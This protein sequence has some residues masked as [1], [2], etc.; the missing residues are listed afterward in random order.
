MGL[1]ER[2]CPGY[3]ARLALVLMVLLSSVDFPILLFWMRQAHVMTFRK[4]VKNLSILLKFFRSQNR[5]ESNMDKQFGSQSA[6]RKGI[7]EN[8]SDLEF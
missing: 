5:L 1:P 6:D 8:R 2:P 7:W 3:D 4:G